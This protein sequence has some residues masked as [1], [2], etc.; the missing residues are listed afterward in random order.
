MINYNIMKKIID[1][2]AKNQLQKKVKKLNKEYNKIYYTDCYEELYYGICDCYSGFVGEEIVSME[3]R[4]EIYINSIKIHKKCGYV[5]EGKYE[6]IDIP[7]RYNYTS[8]MNDR[9]GYKKK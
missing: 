5:I 1:K 2:V 7:Q 3:G 6:T 9:R 4:D 8:G